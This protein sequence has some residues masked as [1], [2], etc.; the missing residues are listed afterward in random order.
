MI[1]F[2]RCGNHNEICITGFRSSRGMKHSAFH[3]ILQHLFHTWFNDVQF[4]LICHFNNCRVDINSDNLNAM[5]GCN[6]GCR[7]S[8]VAQA[9]KTCFHIDY[10]VLILS[11]LS[12]VVV[13]ANNIQA[14][15]HLIY[16]IL[17]VMNPHF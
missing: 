16:D 9:H 10:T 6:N 15:H 2:E 4:P 5:L 8:Y 12:N 1:T 14:L 13:K 17:F 11:L 3:N 7:Q